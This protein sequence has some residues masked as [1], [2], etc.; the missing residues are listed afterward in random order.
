MGRER[1]APSALPF[2]NLSNFDKSHVQNGTI[3]LGILPHNQANSRHFS[4]CFFSMCV[5]EFYCNIG[6]FVFDM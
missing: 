3:H 5:T 4:V 6:H 1:R 2:N